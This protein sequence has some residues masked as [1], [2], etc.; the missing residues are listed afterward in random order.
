M[1]VRRSHDHDRDVSYSDHDIQHVNHALTFLNSAD[2]GPSDTIADVRQWEVTDRGLDHDEIAELRAM[3]VAVTLQSPSSPIAQD[4]IGSFR[5]FLDAGFNLSGTEFMPVATESDFVDSDDSGTD[6][7]RVDF[8][9][10]DEQGQLIS[11][12]LGAYAGYSD[13]TDGTG[14]AAGLPSTTYWVDFADLFGTGPFVDANDDF[15]TRL[16]IDVNNMVA[17]AGISAG[18]SLFYAVYEHDE[19]RPE[20]GHWTT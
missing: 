16:V 5:G 18:V 20:F 9:S 1:S 13:T 15:V 7:A 3:K 10:T 2:S 6:D 14:G 4:E 12:R 19:A 8:K 17:N 11:D